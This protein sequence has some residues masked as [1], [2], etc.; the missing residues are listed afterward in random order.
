MR[1]FLMGATPSFDVAATRPGPE[2]LAM[3]GGNAGNQVIA[4]GLLKSL[5]YSHVAW[6]YARGPADVNAN[7]DH[8]V[9][10]AANFIAPGF[11]FGGMAAFIE[12]TDLPVTILGLGAQS[13]DY[14]TA[15]PL[16]PG[17]ERFLQVLKERCKLI[18]VRGAFTAKVLEHRGIHNLQI[19]GCPSFYMGG[20]ADLVIRQPEW[21]EGMRIAVNG[22]RDVLRHSFDPPK[23][24]RLIR[25]LI[26]EAVKYDAT[27]IPQTETLEIQI[28]DMPGTSTA[29]AAIRELQKLFAG[30]A[31]APRLAEWLR[32]R[33]RT[34]WDVD[35]WFEDM[36]HYD[37]VIGTRFHGA[38]IALQ[39]GTPAFVICHDTR[40][41]EMCEFFGMPHAKINDA[42]EVQIKSL[43]K[44]AKAVEIPK[45]SARK[46]EYTSFL[47][48]AGLKN[49]VDTDA[50][51]GY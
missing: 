1:I 19:I 6:D 39:A 4:W 49:L 47:K 50:S 48:K 17:T 25:Q 24:E 5:D 38:M 34:Y 15:I 31:P 11:D 28:S 43:S 16:L 45:Y 7:F 10:A 40:T 8:I 2:R 12:Q 26:A 3:T 44:D 46:N 18:G 42:R 33:M 23:M 21:H 35:T 14:S 32:T 36:K 51:P 9:I 20:G 27:F 30:A 37:F 22:S 29:E 41:T 13:N